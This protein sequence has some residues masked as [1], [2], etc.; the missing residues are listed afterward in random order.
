MLARGLSCSLEV[1]QLTRVDGAGAST[2]S[3]LS[4][5]GTV[6]SERAGQ[7]MEGAGWCCR[8]APLFR[9]CLQIGLHVLGTSWCETCALLAALTVGHL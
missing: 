3:E 7:R 5:K 8:L 1:T 9:K 2:P 4:G 6:G